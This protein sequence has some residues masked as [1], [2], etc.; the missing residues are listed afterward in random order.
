MQGEQDS[1]HVV[2]EEIR[3]TECRGALAPVDV[4]AGDRLADIVAVLR[5]GRGEPLPVA[6]LGFV[7]VV[8][9]GDWPAVVVSALVIRGL[10][11]HVL[12]RVLPHIGDVQVAGLAVEAEAPRIA[13][14]RRPDLGPGAL[15]VDEGVILGYAVRA[16]PTSIHVD[17]EDLRQEG[18]VVLAVTVGITRTTAVAEGDVQ[19][20]IGA[21]RQHP[22]VVVLRRILLREHDLL[23]GDVA[24]ATVSGGGVARDGVVALLVRVIHVEVAVLSKARV[25]REAEQSLLAAVGKHLLAHVEEEVTSGDGANRAALLD[26]EDTPAAVTSVGDEKRLIE[27][28]RESFQAKR[29]ALGVEAR[30]SA[31]GRCGGNGRLRHASLHCFPGLAATATGGCN[32]GLL[33]RLGRLGCR[34][35]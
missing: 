24:L 13:Q 15:L 14:A 3:A 8:A 32:D 9:L 34:A 1:G 19:V 10:E 16:V 21:E 23:G 26:R 29:D 7:A 18:V 5:N 20:A 22:A 27:L 35:R 33:N 28:A 11:I 17:A 25:E 4:A 2:P 6:L 12:P 30:G 31:G